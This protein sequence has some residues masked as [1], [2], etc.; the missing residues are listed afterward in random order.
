LAFLAS[1]FGVKADAIGLATGTNFPDALTAGP[2]LAQGASAL[3]LTRPTVLPGET[4]G[5]LQA[6]SPQLKSLLIFGDT[7]AVSAQVEAAAKAAA[8]L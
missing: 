4:K 6:A 1:F 2:L 5:L 7:N 8:G 3:V